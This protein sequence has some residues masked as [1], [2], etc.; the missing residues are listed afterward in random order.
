MDNYSSMKLEL[1]ALKW[2]VTEKFRSNLIG[3]QFEVFNDNNSLK[4][5][6]TAKLGAVEQRWA[7]QLASFN[8][9]IKYRS[10][11][12]NTNA[13][14]L[15]RQVRGDQQAPQAEVS[16]LL[17]STSQTTFLP[18]LPSIVSSEVRS[19]E[20]SHQ[21]T[22]QAGKND[23]I[24]NTDKEIRATATMSL[25]SYTNAELIALQKSD[26]ELIPS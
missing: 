2:A 17:R 3:S 12:S 22:P 7:S 21:A 14:A 10:G 26:P 5:L 1:L 4:H 24:Q 23:Q 6:D 25:P 18:S 20:T 11:K 15:S 8:F 9:T 13:D 16:S 19:M